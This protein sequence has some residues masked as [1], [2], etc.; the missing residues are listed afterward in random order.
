MVVEEVERCGAP[1][2][3]CP[4]RA[5]GL[6]NSW[7]PPSAASVPQEFRTKS[8]THVRSTGGWISITSSWSPGASASP[9]GG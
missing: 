6:T 9:V 4:S 8:P 3:P 5:G 2:S 1:S 7:S